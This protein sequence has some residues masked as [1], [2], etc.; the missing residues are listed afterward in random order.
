MKRVMLAIAVAAWTAAPAAAQWAGMP[1]WNNP[2]GGTGVTISGDFGSNNDGAGGGSAFGARASVGIGTLTLTGGAAS[3]DSDVSSDKI[4]SFGATAGFRVLGGSLIP[5]SI[6]LQAGVGR[7]GE[8]DLTGLGTVPAITTI[9][10]SVGIA[11]SLPTPGLS[12]EP[13]ASLG[14]RRYS[15]GGSSDS[16]FGFTIGANMNF[17]ML[18]LHLAYDSEKQDGGS[19]AGIFGVGAH[20]SLKAPI[21]M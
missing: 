15:G 21:G 18:G 20:V 10:G 7:A 17:G 19:T 16:N 13:W 11:A 8:F 9:T 14:I 12:L 2:K 4:T 1:V 3:Y 6:N 5:V